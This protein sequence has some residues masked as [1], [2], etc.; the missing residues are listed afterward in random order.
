MRWQDV[1]RGP[2]LRVYRIPDFILQLEA[3]PEL[4]WWV[5]EQGQLTARLLDRHAGGRGAPYV[6]P[7][8]KGAGLAIR[9][10]AQDKD[11]AQSFRVEG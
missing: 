10:T 1:Q 6:D 5:H 8:V 4:P 11:Q 9:M 3:E 7:A 2:A